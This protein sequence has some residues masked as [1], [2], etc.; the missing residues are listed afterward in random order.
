M[1]C[2]G[3]GGGGRGGGGGGG[4]WAMHSL[5]TSAELLCSGG[6]DGWGGGG[7]WGGVNGSHL[8]T[9]QA[10]KAGHNKLDMSALCGRLQ[11]SGV[12]RRDPPARR[13]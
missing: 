3:G 6:A 12:R 13:H 9:A 8:E 10:S 5:E 11:A 4:G 2:E 1:A 7:G